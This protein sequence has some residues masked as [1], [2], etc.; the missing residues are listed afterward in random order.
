MGINTLLTT[1]KFWAQGG[2]NSFYGFSAG[3]G[4][5]FL[6]RFSVGALVEVGTSAELKGEDPSFEFVTSYKLGKII[7]EEERLEEELIAAEENENKLIEKELTKAEKLALKN[8]TEKQKERSEMERPKDADDLPKN[9]KRSDALVRESK[10]DTKKIKD[11][12]ASARAELAIAEAKSIERQREQAKERVLAL[13]RQQRQDS[14]LKSE[15]AIAEAEQRK[16]E[17]AQ[18]EEVV[19]PKAGEK[20]EE[21][22]KEGSLAPGYYLIANVFGTKK[23]LRSRWP[24]EEKRSNRNSFYRDVN[25]FNYVYLGTYNSISE[26]RAAGIQIKRNL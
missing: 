2:Y 4:G 23:Y 13:Q 21:V 17:L 19:Q 12:I 8:E 18:Q 14:L 11:S 5:R 7:S 25:K 6:K 10:R 22:S 1:N 16:L 9:S 20:Y 26:A 24:Y 3:V 15:A